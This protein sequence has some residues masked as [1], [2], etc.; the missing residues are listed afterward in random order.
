MTT[1]YPPVHRGE[2]SGIQINPNITADS[3][4]AWTAGCPG[5][6]HKGRRFVRVGSK[7]ECMWKAGNS[8]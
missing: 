6:T 1:T 4:V 7:E 8:S 3:S 5:N 2:K